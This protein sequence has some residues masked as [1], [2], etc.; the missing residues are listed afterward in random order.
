[1]DS[2]E[3]AVSDNFSCESYLEHVSCYCS[4][5]Q[6]NHLSFKFDV[7]PTARPPQDSPACTGTICL[8]PQTIF[9]VS[10]FIT[11]LFNPPSV[12]KFTSEYLS[13]PLPTW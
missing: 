10:S 1:M 2:T 4:Q 12:A 8:G 9:E 3:E 11:G 6:A 5:D 13:F 7:G